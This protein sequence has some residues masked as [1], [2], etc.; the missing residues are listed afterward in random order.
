[1]VNEPF[2]TWSFELSPEHFSPCALVIAHVCGPPTAIAVTP[3]GEARDL[4]RR[5]AIPPGARVTSAPDNCPQAVLTPGPVSGSVQSMKRTA[6]LL[7]V[8]VAFAAGTTQAATPSLYKNCTNLNKRYPHGLGKLGARDKTSGEPVTNFRHSTRLYRIAMSY[9]KG[10]D[11]DK[12][13]IACE[14]F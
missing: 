5:A 1:L 7:V 8:T 6:A 14:K 4:D 11:R 2:P 9:N 10:L 3:A 12:D 13:G